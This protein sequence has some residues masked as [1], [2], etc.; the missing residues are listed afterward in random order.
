MSASAAS[1][2][3]KPALAFEPVSEPAMDFANEW[4]PTATQTIKEDLMPS[5]VS[6]DIDRIKSALESRR[7][8]FLV[9]AL[10][11]ASHATVADGELYVEFT[12][13]AR[14]LRDTL[15]KSDNV[16]I[17]REICQ[18]IS[19]KELAVRIMVKDPTLA[20]SDA[21]LSR[22]E[23]ERQEQNRLRENVEKHPVVQ[24]MLRTFRGEIVDVRRIDKSQS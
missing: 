21:P 10:E 15:A 24:Q 12:P 20:A 1:F 23:E 17:L 11:G 16:K 22:E 6:S 8:M 4:Q 18:E 9:T 2:A 14:H 19:G 13:E 5:P 3:A 7:K